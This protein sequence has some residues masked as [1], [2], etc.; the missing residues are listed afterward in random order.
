MW[1]QSGTDN[2]YA[3][4]QFGSA[5]LSLFQLP[6]WD[7]QTD[8]PSPLLCLLHT[9]YLPAE[10]HIAARLRF[11]TLCGCLC[12]AACILWPTKNLYLPLHYHR[13]SNQSAAS[14]LITHNH[15]QKHNNTNLENVEFK[16]IIQTLSHTAPHVSKHFSVCR[17]V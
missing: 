12:F 2:C 13:M 5:H 11:F 7:L 15:L 8:K 4:A 9:I 14:V 10:L 17:D 1:A 3:S 16:F 6:L